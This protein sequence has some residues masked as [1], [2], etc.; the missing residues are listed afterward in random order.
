MLTQFFETRHGRA[1]IGFAATL[2]LAGL[3]VAV[4]ELALAHPLAVAVPLA[5]LVVYGICWLVAG[6]Q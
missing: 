1:L 2:G 4:V 6:N 5:L 3:M